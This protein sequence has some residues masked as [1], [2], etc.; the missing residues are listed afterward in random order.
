M[1]IL[2]KINNYSLK[3]QLITGIF[4]AYAILIIFFATDFFSKQRE[5]LEQHFFDEASLMAKTLAVS[6][7]TQVLNSDLAG[8]DEIIETIS[9]YDETKYVFVSNRNGKILAHSDKTLVGKYVNDK[10]SRQLF[11]LSTYQVISSSDKMIDVAAP[12][13]LHNDVVGWVRLGLSKEKS[14][15]DENKKTFQ[16]LGFIFSSLLIGFLLIYWISHRITS[17]LDMIIGV[18]KKVSEGDLTQRTSVQSQNE[19]GVLGFVFNSMLDKINDDINNQKKLEIEKEKIFE[20]LRQSQKMEAI[21]QLTGGIAHDFNNILAGIIGFTEI[22]AQKA[23]HDEK[24]I[25]YFNQVNKLAHRARDLVRQMLIYTRGGDPDPKVV[26]VQKVIGE[27]LELLQPIISGNLKINFLRSSDPLNIKIDPVQL[28]QIIMNLSINARDAMEGKQG[29]LNIKIERVQSGFH[30]CHSCGSQFQGS[31]LKIEISDNG[32]GISE[33]HFRKIFE[34]FFTT[35]AISKGTG[36]GLSMV[37]GI[38]HRHQ[39]H[40]RVFSEK[41]KGTAF[42]IYLPE[43]FEHEEIILK[44]ESKVISSDNLRILIVDDEDFMR[45]FAK[46]FLEDSGYRCVVA[47]NGKMAI[48]ILQNDAEGFDLVITDY[49][50]PEMNGIE[51]ISFIRL[52]WN[53]KI[54]I[55]LSSGNIDIELEKDYKHLKIDAILVKPYDIDEALLIINDVLKSQDHQIA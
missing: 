4:F 49:T 9:N 55:I 31:Y 19:L 42:S 34:P 46:E 41:D 28:Q 33:D 29:V 7:N 36:M 27:T 43:V 47:Q 5:I 51:L 14:I 2:N 18:A 6:T 44:R 50:M 52:Q 39:G 35:K 13:K 37:H 54:K 8:L 45:D 11:E 3:F 23:K 40:I 1:N 22:G 32:S 15:L 12:I 17:Q 16:R 48:D 38:V 10:K 25:N 30:D 26:N 24:S 20:Q 53:H 21:G